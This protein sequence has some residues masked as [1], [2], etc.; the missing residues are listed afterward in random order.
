MRDA[1]WRWECTYNL[2]QLGLALSQ[3]QDAFGCLP[4]PYVA[5]KNGKPL[6]SW[7]VL[8]LPYFQFAPT[9]QAWQRES[10]QDEAW[11]GP[12]NSK[13][14]TFDSSAAGPWYRC[15]METILCLDRHT[16]SR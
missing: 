11:D 13:W 7:R 14:M 3:Y 8:I 9:Y 10:H 1:H 15:L 2:K 6:Y 12:N 5:D 4:P 16:T